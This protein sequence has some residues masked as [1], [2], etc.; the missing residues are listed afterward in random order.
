M[1]GV[2]LDRF[3]SLGRFWGGKGPWGAKLTTVCLCRRT[4]IRRSLIGAVKV[5]P[6]PRMRP[7]PEQEAGQNDVQS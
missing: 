3:T 1:D 2:S 5:S 7:E 6:G 4:R